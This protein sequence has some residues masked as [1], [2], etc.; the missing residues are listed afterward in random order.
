MVDLTGEH[1]SHALGCTYACDRLDHYLDST[2][3]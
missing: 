2:G 3:S 1:A